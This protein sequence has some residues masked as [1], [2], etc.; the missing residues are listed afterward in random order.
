MPL[1][2]TFVI[3]SRSISQGGGNLRYFFIGILLSVIC[4]FVSLAVWGIDKAYSITGII[5]I[6]FIGISMVFSGSMVSGDRMRANFATESVE[7]RRNRNAVTFRLAL[8][9]IPNLVI[10]F[11]IYYYFN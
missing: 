5:G 3:L 7:D 9:G 1:L 8:I 10:A 11:F 6:L 4:V 2:E